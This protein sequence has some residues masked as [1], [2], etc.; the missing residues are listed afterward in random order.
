MSKILEEIKSRYGNRKPSGSRTTISRRQCEESLRDLGYLG[1]KKGDD[2]LVLSNP[3]IPMSALFHNK[4]VWWYSAG[5]V[6]HEDS[7]AR[8]IRRA[9]EE[10]HLR[11][12]HPVE[13]TLASYGIKTGKRHFDIEADTSILVDVVA[14]SVCDEASRLLGDPIDTE[15][16]IEYLVDHAQ[17]IYEHN[18]TF[19][20]NIRSEANHGNA[21]RDH[22]Y[23]Y[24]RHWLTSELVKQVHDRRKLIDSGFSMGEDPRHP[25]KWW[26][27]AH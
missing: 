24:M 10:H 2:P 3:R 6:L 18:P 14:E 5:K 23:T 15:H 9:K 27:T 7:Y 21:G 8:A 11:G 13:E 25:G 16:M 22:L 26:R 1:Y 19:R 17:Q 20:K 4:Q 12:G